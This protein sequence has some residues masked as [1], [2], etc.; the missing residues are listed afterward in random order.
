[1]KLS[2][3]LLAASC[4]HSALA[5]A[6]PEVT[7]PPPP[8]PARSSKWVFSL[9]P[10]SFQRNPS[11]DFNVITEMTAEG[12][13]FP[14]PTS[15]Q[16]LYYIEQPGKF[17]QLGWE[18]P[19]N[20]KPPP[21]AEL[22]RAMQ[23]ALATNGYLQSTAS[24]PAARLLVVFNF[25]SFARFSTG[26]EEAEQ[27]AAAEQAYEE[28]ISRQPPPNPP[29]D[30]PQAAQ[31]SP[32][33]AD[34]LLP[35]VMADVSKRRDVLERA[36]LIAGAKF[37]K[38]LSD[39]IEKEIQYRQTGAGFGPPEDDPASPFNIFRN[40]NEKLIYFVEESFSSCYFV[41]A[42]AYDYAAM[43]KGNRLLL[44][45]TKMTV[46]SL[47]ISMTESLP[48]LIVSAGPYLGREMSEAATMTRRISREGHVEIGTPVVVPDSATPSATEPSPPKKATPAKP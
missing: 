24:G 42:S 46:N 29:P 18:S 41:I 8:E 23:R 39:A 28:A 37:A 15:Q 10:K 48:A 35:Y 45:R 34:Q 27:E 31:V 1:M 4:L 12:K 19:A 17:T 9:L 47:G 33:T 22:E 44:W 3:A 14:K 36:S 11:V 38:E 32:D 43:G 40:R 5:A 13:R 21:I 25:G 20:E 26:M 6:E 2:H 7:V 30:P 16:P